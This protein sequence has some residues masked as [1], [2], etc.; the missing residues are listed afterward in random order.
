MPNVNVA[1]LHRYP[2]KGL[3]AQ[4]LERAALETGRHFPGDRLYAIE[5]GP[6]GYDPAQ[7]VHQP[8]FK[9]LVLMRNPKLSAF[10]TSYEDATGVL[11]ITRDGKMQV[12]GDLRTEQGRSSIEAF[13]ADVLGDEMRG[14]AKVLA[15]AGSYRFMDSARS[16]FVSLLNLASLRALAA[17]T[18]RKTLDPIRFRMNIGLEGLPPWGEF[19]L[20]G[21]VI[22]VGGARLRTLK[23]TE[24]CVAINAAPGQG[25][26]DLDLI[27]TMQQRLRHNNCGIYAEVIDG[28][29]V[30]LGDEMVVEREVSA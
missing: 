20:I 7:P 18:G 22:R 2:V 26:R 29:V 24:R 23:A 1:F 19:D 28:G 4:P 21:Q 12:A 11:T 15:A 30:E 5:N 25:I 17:M 16:G 8:K 13:F 3:S 27:R 6:S 10:S 9:Y 14:P